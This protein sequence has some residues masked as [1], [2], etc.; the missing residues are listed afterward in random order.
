[1]LFDTDEERFGGQGRIDHGM[2]YYTKPSGGLT[3]QHYLNLYIPARTAIVLKK[4][5]FKRVW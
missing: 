1:V 2:T 4:Q 3:S 5:A